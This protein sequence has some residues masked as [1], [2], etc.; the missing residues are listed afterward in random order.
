MQINLD[1]D[2]WDPY[3]WELIICAEAQGWNILPNGLTIDKVIRLIQIRKG[4]EH[5][6]K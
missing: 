2:T 1:P 5:D 3:M 4:F 6:D